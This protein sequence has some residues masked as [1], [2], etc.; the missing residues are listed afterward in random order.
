MNIY[1]SEFNLSLIGER[2]VVI[3][4]RDL[5]QYGDLVAELECRGV[6]TRMLPLNGYKFAHKE[7]GEHTAVFVRQNM[8][9]ACSSI[10][11]FDGM[12]YNRYRAAVFMEYQNCRTEPA[13]VEDLL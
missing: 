10:G 6:D 4:C 1:F 2:E 5:E 7:I 12:Y 11:H 8:Q 3:L 13:S 9:A